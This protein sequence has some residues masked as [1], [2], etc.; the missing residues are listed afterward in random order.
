MEALKAA[1]LGLISRFNTLKAENEAL[2]AQV[3]SIGDQTADI[4]EITDAANGAQL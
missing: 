2:K 3:A 4:Q 1:V